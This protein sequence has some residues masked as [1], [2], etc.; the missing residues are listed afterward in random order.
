MSSLG[1]C[2]EAVS[3]TFFLMIDGG[4]IMKRREV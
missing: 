3:Q 2:V 1:D 4:S